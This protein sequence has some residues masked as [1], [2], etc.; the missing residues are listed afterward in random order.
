MRVFGQQK[1]L[2]SSGENIVCFFGQQRTL[3]SPG[4]NVNVCVWLQGRRQTNL[5]LKADGVDGDHRLTGV[6]LQR[7]R[8]EGLW[9]EEARDPQHL[10][11]Q[12]HTAKLHS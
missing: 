8:Q 2:L 1:T 10:K 4:E 9:E 12:S 5:K 3:A 11:Q 7:P 6:V